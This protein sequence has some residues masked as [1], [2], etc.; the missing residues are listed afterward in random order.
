MKTDSVTTESKGADESLVLCCRADNDL[1]VV[2]KTNGFTFARYESA[3]EAVDSAADNAGVLILAD[4]YP[5]Q[6]LELSE[7]ILVKAKAKSL[8]L[9]VEFP[10]ALGDQKF[11]VPEKLDRARAVIKSED[12]FGGDLKPMT[13][14]I[15]HDCRQVGTAS[16]DSHIV[17]AVVAGTHRAVF[18]LPQETSPLLYEHSD[19]VMVATTGLS[20]FV[21]ARYAP[22]KAW[23][24]IWRSILGWAS[25][26]RIAPTLYWTPRACPA[27]GKNEP[28]PDD[29][30]LQALERFLEWHYKSGL[31]VTPENDNEFRS[32]H[33]EGKYDI[34]VGGLPT[35]GDGRFGLAEGFWTY[36]KHDGSQ[37][38]RVIRRVDNNAETAMALALGGK[39][40]GREKDLD[41]SKNLLDYIYFLSDFQSG[42]MA[43]PH[44]PAFGLTAWQLPQNGPTPPHSD[45]TSYLASDCRQVTA[46]LAAATTLA[47]DRWDNRHLRFMLAVERV[48]AANG[49]GHRMT[50]RQLETNGWRHYCELLDS[51]AISDSPPGHFLMA[52]KLTGHEPF[53]VKAKRNIESIMAAYP[54]DFKRWNT[55]NSGDCNFLLTL[56]WL[57]RLEDTPQHRE[58]LYQVAKNLLYTQEPCGAIRDTIGAPGRGVVTGYGPCK[59]N[60]DYGTTEATLLQEDGDPITDMLYCNGFALVSLHEAY[61]AT[62][63]PYFKEAEDKLA[64]FLC[65]VQIRSDSLPYLDGTWFRTFDID[66]WEPF[67]SAADVGWGGWSIETGWGAAW[68]AMGLALRQLNTTLWDVCLQGESR[69][70]K[71]MPEVSQLMAQNDGSPMSSDEDLEFTE[72]RHAA[73]GKPIALANEPHPSYTWKGAESLVDG[74]LGNPA[75]LHR[76]WLGFAKTQSNDDGD[77]VATVDLGEPTEIRQ[78]SVNCLQN[79]QAAIYLPKHVEIAISDDGQQFSV[80]ETIDNGVPRTEAGV[81]ARVFGKDDFYI[82]ARYVRVIAENA[83]VIPPGMAG[84]GD[85]SLLFVDEII[86]NPCS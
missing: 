42:V 63:D 30:E 2:L 54:D 8:R 1:N 44:H 24:V 26:G 51:L 45:K 86:I 67:G 59:C 41:T 28:L 9:F 19:D 69:F 23:Q 32:R 25:G 78:I 33:Q 16:P 83:G 15:I 56:A 31:L 76:Y 46:A 53:L 29:C 3:A 43:D 74:K 73:I 61:A 10:G 49:F 71:I 11:S 35:N 60:E 50:T 84:A 81:F 80:V 72:I 39:A 75:E 66:A 12:F 6:P 40:T 27:Y 79:I 68:G 65:R 37:P 17:T 85:N 52:Y 82:T 22:H 58:W 34:P 55:T 18:G 57:V 4:G 20:H 36:V 62:G 70:K 5:D 14:L 47:D 64:E 7:G 77:M 48:T 38:F 21:T 13:I